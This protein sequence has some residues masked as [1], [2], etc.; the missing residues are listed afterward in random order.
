[1]WTYNYPDEL[2]HHGVKGMKWGVRRAQRKAERSAKK[3]VNKL[4]KG[5][6]KNYGARAA[7]SNVAAISKFDKS[8]Y[9]DLYEASES[10]RLF[11]Q[12]RFKKN[13]KDKSVDLYVGDDKNPTMR[14]KMEKGEQFS[15]K[16]IEESSR[17]RYEEYEAYQD[18]V[19]QAKDLT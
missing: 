7:L 8:Q 10:G 5:L 3:E 15:A 18:R 19:N 4:Y 11:V 17:I 6:S 13:Y 9:K 16:F 1:M 12:T 2:Y 14:I